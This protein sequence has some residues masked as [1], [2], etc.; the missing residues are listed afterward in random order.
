VWLSVPVAVA[1]LLLSAPAHAAFPGANGRLVFDSSDCTACT[2]QIYSIN[3]DG[4]DQTRVAAN[5]FDDRGPAWSPDGQKLAFASNRDR[6]DPLLH[7]I[8]S[9]NADGTGP[10]RLTNTTDAGDSPG[11]PAWSPDG[12]RIMYVGRAGLYVMNA[13]GSGNTP[14]GTDG[15]TV[16][17][18]PSW[19]PDGRRIAWSGDNTQIFTANPDGTAIVKLT[20]FAN[21]QGGNYAPDW[22]PDASK[23]VFT[24]TRD[25]N[26]DQIYTM[27]PDGTNQTRLT[28]V[29]G[30][31]LP[32]WSP[33]G[34]RIAFLSNRGHPNTWDIYTMNPDGTGQT[35]VTELTT[36]PATAGSLDWQS[37]PINGYP[38][39]KGA[40]PFQT[41]LSV[42]YKP[43]ASPN[44]QH[45][46]P[47][48]VLSCNPPQQ[49]SDFLTVGTLDANG[50]AAKAI[51]SV[52]YDVKP[53]T[54]A[55][56]ADDADVKINV[57][58]KDVR[59]KSDLSDYAGELG[60]T[61]ARRITDKLSTPAPDGTTQAATT[62]DTPFSITVPC[63]PTTADT[64]VGSTCSISTTADAILPGQ[65][66]ENAR[67]NW[68]LGQIQVYDGGSDSDADTTA[69]NTLFMDEGIFVP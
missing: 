15:H 49:T 66:T 43:C 53:G 26:I 52:R 56:P 18:K 33:D 36:D 67:S 8:Y 35:Q 48:A 17:G 22:S 37:L 23:I 41:Y 4:T 13:D 28:D 46:S 69:D 16:N 27:N 21:G 10:T 20:R 65:V 39:P 24:S 2:S 9:M 31:R 29:G 60:V 5:T 44:E 50:Q 38:R 57:S 64:T 42:A 12:Q 58:V 6:S 11:G 32:V 40:T 51:G 63:A 59:M 47:L 55:V 1:L 19:A 14:I 45:G 68:E 62:Q 54:A 30:S 25:S 34:T 61:S 7:D 3:P